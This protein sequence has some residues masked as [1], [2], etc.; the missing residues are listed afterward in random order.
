MRAVQV[1]PWHSAVVGSGEQLD[2]LDVSRRGAQAAATPA[3]GKPQWNS[4]APSWNP[5]ATGGFAGIF[6]VDPLPADYLA[7]TIRADQPV[8]LTL[9]LSRYE[10]F[11]GFA[12]RPPASGAGVRTSDA[13]IWLNG[14]QVEL[15]NRLEGYERVPVAKR[16]SWHERFDWH[17]AVLVDL[18]LQPGENHLVVSL[19][20][21]ERKP[22]FN[23]V[24]FCSQPAPALWSMI[25]ND[26][27][28][29]GNRLLEYVDARWFD[30][31]SGWFSQG[32]APQFERQIIE[33]LT[34]KLGA[35]GD[36][37]RH[38]LDA[39]VKSQV[40]SSDIGWL[41]LCVAAAELHAALAG[42]AHGRSSRGRAR[43]ARG[44]GF[45][46]QRFSHSF[47]NRSWSCGF[48]FLANNSVL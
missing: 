21:P 47:S 27:P 30:F 22:W 25:E 44:S 7:T 33:E 4:F 19:H 42:R 2:A 32:E 38:R 26:F 45:G 10:W 40:T 36:A 41:D 13:L 5:W 18:T 34:Q 12:Y 46:H 17:D 28:R 20:K 48:T 37:I 3:T 24:R 14:Q 31:A 9:E 43:S 8:T 15:R 16:R 29:S 39:L 23:C 11:G 1:G 6:S 35:D